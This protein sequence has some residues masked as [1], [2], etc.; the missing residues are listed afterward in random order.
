LKI[1][2]YSRYYPFPVAHELAR[3]QLEAGHEVLVA[4]WPGMSRVPRGRSIYEGVPVHCFGVDVHS[5]PVRFSLAPLKVLRE[6]NDF[7]SLTELFKRFDVVHVHAPTFYSYPAL[8]SKLGITGWGLAKRLVKT[9]AVWTFHGH[10]NLIARYAQAIYNEMKYAE[11][12]TAVSKEAAKAL[13]VEWIPNGV[14]TQRFKPL[15]PSEIVEAKRRFNVP[16]GKV[17]VLMTARWVPRKGHDILVEALTKLS[18]AERIKVYV[19]FVGPLDVG[20]IKYHDEVVRRLVKL[21]VGYGEF[22][23]K[24]EDLPL[25]YNVCDVFVHPARAEGDPLVLPEAMACGKPCVISSSCSYSRIIN[26]VNGFVA[27]S[28]EGLSSYL[29]VLIHDEGLRKS[30]GKRAL[31]TALK[32]DWARINELYMKLYLRA[33][34]TQRH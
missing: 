26:G 2:H 15:G 10:L 6:V 20:Y 19:M 16:E 11:E 22:F 31:E 29:R 24:F 28:V 5:N 14:N 4:C 21:G 30:L 25:V 8:Y 33:L 17:V 3:R 27:N 9:P 13:G 7:T 1:L 34:Y 23:V 12:K 32:Y 18:E